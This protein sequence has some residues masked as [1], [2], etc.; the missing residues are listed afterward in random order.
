MCVADEFYALY[1]FHAIVEP[2]SYGGIEGLKVQVPSLALLD[3]CNQCVMSERVQVVT[4]A[5]MND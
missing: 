1:A 5:L 4:K 3:L 2:V